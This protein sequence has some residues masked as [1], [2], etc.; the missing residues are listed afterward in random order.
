ML[1]M[2]LCIHSGMWFD[3]TLENIQEKGQT[4]ACSVIYS[5]HQAIWENIE[6]A[7]RMNIFVL[8]SVTRCIL[9]SQKI[10]PMWLCI[11]SGRIFWKN[12][13]NKQK[14][15]DTQALKAGGCESEP[16]ATEGYWSCHMISVN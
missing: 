7:H 10:Q 12:I 13:W 15:K 1:S 6:N 16:N 14:R 4:S 5:S 8:A 9:T 3:E 2:W 11:L